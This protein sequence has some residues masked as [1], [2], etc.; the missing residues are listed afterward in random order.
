MSNPYIKRKLHEHLGHLPPAGGRPPAADE[1]R[2]PRQGSDAKPSALLAATLLLSAAVLLVQPVASTAAC[3]GVNGTE[4]FETYA[5]FFQPP[6]TC[7]YVYVDSEPGYVVSTPVPSNGGTRSFFP[8]GDLEQLDLK[9]GDICSTANPSGAYSASF[10]FYTGPAPAG[11]NYKGVG[12][13]FMA[14]SSGALVWKT[15]MIPGVFFR[16]GGVNGYT[17][18]P[19][20]P[21]ILIDTWYNGSVTIAC[22]NTSTP[23]FDGTVT[24]TIDTNLDGNTDYG[25]TVT[26]SSTWGTGIPG[27]FAYTTFPIAGGSPGGV[28]DGYFDNLAIS[29]YGSPTVP[30]GT[31]V[32]VVNLAGGDVDASGDII[33][34]RTNDAPPSNTGNIRTYDAGTLTSLATPFDSECGRTHGVNALRSNSGERYVVFLSCINNAPN[35]DFVSIRNAALGAP[36]TPSVCSGTGFCIQD[37]PD[38]EL[39]GDSDQHYEFLSMEEFPMD[40]SRTT[41]GLL[42]DL[43]IYMAFAVSTT[44]GE[45]GIVTYVMNNNGDDK[46]QITLQNIAG[47][48]N[49][50][51]QICTVR[52]STGDSYLYGSDSAS[53]VKG[54]KVVFDQENTIT[55]GQAPTL[56]VDMDLV[57]Q[58]TAATSGPRGIG[59]GEGKLAILNTDKITL[60][61]RTSDGVHTGP[62]VTI[63]NCGTPSITCIP[64]TFGATPVEGVTMSGDGRWVAYVESGFVH[65]IST[66]NRAAQNGIPALKQGEEVAQAALPTGNFKGVQLKGNGGSAWVF[67]DVRIQLYSLLFQYTTGTDAACNPG[68][69]GCGP[70]CDDCV[71]EPPEDNDSDNDG[72]PDDEELITDSPY[73][74]LFFWMVLIIVATALLSWASRAGFGGMV[75]GMEVLVI[76]VMGIIFA[77]PDKISP[78]PVV[79]VFAIALIALLVGWARR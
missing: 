63:G 47:A 6:D 34:A 69:I 79:V 5:P 55:G 59:C 70:V 28:T 68:D 18:F 1:A 40:Y 39:A 24:A 71:V 15:D 11:T 72:I 19:G 75:Y 51:D 35:V 31:S 45:I 56:S 78:W 17:A 46:S 76:Y 67:T 36:D 41:G 7:L 60:W 61:N 42:N 23:T 74:W 32:T 14:G 65:F 53:Q 57:F 4:N 2:Q 22:D 44:A 37:V 3:T 25:R 43:A 29:G 21:A 9:G 27:N 38:T 77:G 33:I 52:D 10:T 13:G 26:A 16:S 66:T 50:V 8:N 30:A 54:Y 58:G 49:P 73:F 48:A 12:L 62:Y 20:A 64:K